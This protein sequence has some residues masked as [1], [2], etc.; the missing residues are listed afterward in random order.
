MNKFILND[1]NA[2]E[3][4]LQYN[5]KNLQMIIDSLDHHPDVDMKITS[6]RDIKRRTVT[7][8]EHKRKYNNFN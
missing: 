2:I 3:K 4:A 7:L 6:D 5:D 8:R 1:E